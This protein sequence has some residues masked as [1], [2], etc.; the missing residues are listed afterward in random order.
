MTTP[1]VH[2]NQIK[3][4]LTIA[5]KVP[6]KLKNLSASTQALIPKVM[7]DIADEGLDY[8]RTT[9]GQKLRSSRTTYQNA[10][11]MKITGDGSF[12]LT[13]RGKL[14]YVIETGG[15]KFDMKPGFLKNA[16]PAPMPQHGP[17]RKMPRA[18]AEAMG[19]TKSPFTKWRVIPLNTNRLDPMGTNVG[20]FRTVTDQSPQGSWIHPGWG[21]GK[22]ISQDVKIALTNDII[23]RHLHA[24]FK[25]G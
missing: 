21:K 6:E 22:H 14:P 7:K 3:V 5:V 19:A 16:K 15:K 20:A 4:Q 2:S 13:L 12:K 24:L 1:R 11:S 18:V 8:W 17:G 23:P 9:A 25:L 10:L